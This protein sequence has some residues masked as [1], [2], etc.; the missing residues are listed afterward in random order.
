MTDSGGGSYR[1]AHELARTNGRTV[2]VDGVEWRVYE[3][4]PG[5]YDRRGPATLIFESHD[6]F[7]RIRTYPADWRTL[8]DEALYAISLRV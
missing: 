8:S 1:A 2:L 5:M 3:M 6:V 7:R 4:P